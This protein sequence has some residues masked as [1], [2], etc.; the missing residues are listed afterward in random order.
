VFIARPPPDGWYVMIAKWTGLAVLVGVLAITW[1][2]MG[3]GSTGLLHMTGDA[4]PGCSY[5]EP[6]SPCAG[7]FPKGIPIGDGL[8][9]IQ[10]EDFS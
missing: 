2:S 10:A 8:Y 1:I 7:P 5:F 9:L 3:R 6:L 4:G